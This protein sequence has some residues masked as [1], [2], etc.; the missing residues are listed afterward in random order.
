VG[1]LLLYVPKVFFS[2]FELALG[3]EKNI[4]I[5][6]GCCCW[7]RSSSTKHRGERYQGRILKKESEKVFFFSLLLLLLLLPFGKIVE[8]I[9][10]RGLKKGRRNE[11]ENTEEVEEH[12]LNKK[13]G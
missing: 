1:S 12:F 13:I 2:Y 11:K 9:N 3:E 5:V 10:K 4:Y 7:G 8:A 6:A